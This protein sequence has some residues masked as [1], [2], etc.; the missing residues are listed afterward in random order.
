MKRLAFATGLCALVMAMSAPARADYTVIQFE[1]SWCE[2]WS[3]STATPWGANW[4]KLTIGLPT[5]EAASAT[6]ADARA[7]G[8]C[9]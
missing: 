9:H 7:Q 4:R 6:L 1:N 8:V 2:V 3:D 5:W